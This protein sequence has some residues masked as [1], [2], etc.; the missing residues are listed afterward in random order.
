MAGDLE[1]R[2][3]LREIGSEI[4][5]RRESLGLSI[6]D[7]SNKTRL[8]A[9]YLLAVEEGDDTEAPG[10]TYFRAFIKTYATFLG[11]DG[12]AYSMA[13]QKALEERDAPPPKG[14]PKPQPPAPARPDQA[15]PAKKPADKPEEPPMPKLLPDPA[16]SGSKPSEPAPAA[17]PVAPPSVTKGA[18]PA[19]SAPLAPPHHAATVRE[20]PQPRSQ[21]RPRRGKTS[22][23]WVFLLILA[24]AAGAYAVYTMQNKPQPEPPV[25]ADP[26]PG[27]DPGTTEP[28]EPT[29]PTEPTVT[30]PVEPPAPKVTRTDVDPGAV[31]FTV[32]GS[33]IELTLKTGESDDSYCWLR[34]VADGELLFEKT[35]SPGQ[36]ETVT[37]DSEIVIRAGKPWV[38]SLVVNGEDQGLAGEF[39]P[40]KDITITAAP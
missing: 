21:R 15:A 39:G 7:A 8:R 40:V 27:S 16:P 10:T 14:K 29:E 37:A 17:R 34:V 23:V 26:D 3:K 1:Y 32:D 2:E 4:R 38:L 30:E 18:P 22:P 25:A 36:E 19:P 9:K 33:P 6:E 20:T 11:L 24:L 13:Y 28:S 31:T 5:A 35:M 12:S